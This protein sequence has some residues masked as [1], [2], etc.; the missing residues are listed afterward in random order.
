MADEFNDDYMDEE[1]YNNNLKEMFYQL[2]NEIVDK[3]DV[4]GDPKSDQAV[5]EVFNTRIKKT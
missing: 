1:T 2:S 4:T 5:I 3:T